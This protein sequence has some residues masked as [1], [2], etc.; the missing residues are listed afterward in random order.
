MNAEDAAGRQDGGWSAALADIG[1]IR[2]GRLCYRFEETVRFYRDLV[3]LPLH[4]TFEASYGESGAIF[5]LPGPSL[6]FELVQSDR[7]VAGEVLQQI[8]LYFPDSGAQAAAMEG[9]RSAGIEP[10]KSH[11]YWEANGAVTYLDP[12]GHG[13]VF[14]PFVYGSQASAARRREAEPEFPGP[15]G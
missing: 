10:V 9:L 14:A 5:G 4:E 1:A 13:V 6:T 8:C 2:F 11:P 3:G 15:Q 7:P 12:E